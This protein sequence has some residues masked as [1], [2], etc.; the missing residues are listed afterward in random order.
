[1]GK[2]VDINRAKWYTCP[3]C[4][5]VLSPEEYHLFHKNDTCP[6]C[7]IIDIIEFKGVTD[8]E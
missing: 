2:I 1:M 5:W 7:G 8:E 6:A 3:L 4:M